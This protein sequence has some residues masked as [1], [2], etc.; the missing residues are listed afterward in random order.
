MSSFEPDNHLKQAEERLGNVVEAV[1]ERGYDDVTEELDDYSVMVTQFE[2]RKLVTFQLYEVYFPPKRHEFELQL[3]TDI[4]EAVAQSKATAFLGTA[5]FSGIIGSTAYEVSKRLFAYVARKFQRDKKRSR[6]F[7]EIEMNLRSI[8]DYFDTREQARIEDIS[9]ALDIEREKLE[10]LL[11]LLGFKCRRREKQQVW[12]R[13][14][15]W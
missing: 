4:V 3:L 13:P 5:A 12:I 10:P 7:R 8:R 2:F 14:S 9:E 11:K 1:L 15:V 6:P